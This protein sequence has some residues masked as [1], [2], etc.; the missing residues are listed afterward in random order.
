MGND[1]RPD[2]RAGADDP[3]M[4]DP[5]IA[6][7]LPAGQRAW[8]VM[9]PNAADYRLGNLR[10]AFVR[11]QLLKSQGCFVA[12]RILIAVGADELEVR[13]V[14]PQRVL[15]RQIARVPLDAVVTEQVVPEGADDL[16]AP[17]IRVSTRRR[18]SSGSRFLMPLVELRARTD[19]R[20]AQQMTHLLLTEHPCPAHLRGEIS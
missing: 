20:R 14:L 16:W 4:L 1:E 15:G 18:T 13:H 3:T 7:R 19:D 2:E 12:E 9:A 8:A 17:A 6:R 11:R 10:R 5:G